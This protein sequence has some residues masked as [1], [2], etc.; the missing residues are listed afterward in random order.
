MCEA[1]RVWGLTVVGSVSRPVVFSEQRCPQPGG[2]AEIP[3][4][5]EFTVW[6][7]PNLYYSNPVWQWMQL[8]CMIYLPVLSPEHEINFAY[9]LLPFVT[10]SDASTFRNG[11]S[12]PVHMLQGLHLKFGRATCR[13]LVLEWDQ[14]PALKRSARPSN[15]T[16]AKDMQ[17][18]LWED[19]LPRKT[20]Q[21]R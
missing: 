11:W 3:Q 15:H 10:S 12:F 13:G 17:K 4:L 21:K 5:H 16:R 7:F 14:V 1:W 8:T 2:V 9:I 20:S 18:V 6:F 19:S